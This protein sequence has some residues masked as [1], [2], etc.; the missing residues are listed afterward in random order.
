MNS[1]DSSSWRP[2]TEALRLSEFAE[3]GEES[4]GE[5]A[6]WMSALKAG[7]W[8]AR[9]DSLWIWSISAWLSRGAWFSFSALSESPDSAD[10]GRVEAPREVS[11][12]D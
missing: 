6:R 3:K 10:G 8:S 7:S 1:G 12:I 2:Y 5:R 11:A 9:N 4:E